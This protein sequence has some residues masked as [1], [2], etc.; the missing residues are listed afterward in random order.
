MDTESEPLLLG[1]LPPG[2]GEVERS[3]HIVMDENIMVYEPEDNDMGS[4]LFQCLR[5]FGGCLAACLC[6]PCGCCCAGPVTEVPEGYRAIVYKFGKFDRIKPPGTYVRN[7]G[8]EKYSR[9]NIQLR[10]M[11]I[12]QQ[13]VITKD[14]VS[15][16]VDA[17][18]F[19]RVKD[20]KKAYINV[21][22]YA[23]NI[24][25]LAQYTLE[26]LLGE[27]L[28]EDLLQQRDKVTQRIAHIIKEETA[29]WGIEVTRL[30]IR[31]IKIPKDLVRVMASIAEAS[32]EGQ[33]KI[34]VA[35]AELEA[36]EAYAEAANKLMKSEGAMQL[37]YFQTLSEIS[38]EKNSTI[39]IPSSIQNLLK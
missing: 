33:A 27:Y 39:I 14:G 12:P 37:R 4:R 31:D 34:I 1:S 29:K 23:A 26:V 28:L 11:T 35:K 24:Q 6:V 19:Y 2:K 13:T 38:A 17:V 30:E 5:S 10:T 16:T 25:N 8:S 21:R 22:N 32:R 15:T 20:I 18:C 7:M 36:A 3:D 9:V